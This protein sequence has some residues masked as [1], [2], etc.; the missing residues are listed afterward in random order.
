MTRLFAISALAALAFA[1]SPRDPLEPDPDLRVMTWNI[2]RGHGAD[3]NLDLDRIARVI[4][5][6]D[7]DLLALQEVDRGAR[8][9]GRRNL[10]E[11]IA[12][13]TDMH[14]VFGKAIDVQGGEFGNAILSKEPIA[15]RKNQPLPKETE[16]ERRALLRAG[17]EIA[18]EPLV[19]MSTHFSLEESDRLRQVEAIARAA[20]D[21][22]EPVLA[23]L[24]LND[25]P[26]SPT[27]EAIAERF[28]DLW[29]DVGQPPGATWPAA[30]PL[31]RIDYI[32]AQ[33]PAASGWIPLRARVPSTRASDHRPVVLEFSRADRALGGAVRVA[34]RP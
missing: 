2:H 16:R 17:A 33:M 28:A 19:F 34:R 29:T 23:G 22:A 13:R 4:E 27:H 32:L 12:E 7:P 9:T 15:W 1:C 11:E 30:A 3:G 6:E 25:A 5:A 26:G 24:D 10:D 8:R 20:E 18:G 31:R 21:H 14:A